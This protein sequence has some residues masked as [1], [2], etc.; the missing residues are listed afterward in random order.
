MDPTPTPVPPQP[1]PPMP[2][3]RSFIGPIILICIGVFFLV[4]NFVPSFDPWEIMARY[5]PVILIL[6]GLGRV[7]DYYAGKRSPG[8]TGA[9]GAT[10]LVVAVVLLMCLLGLGVWRS[11]SDS[12]N[13]PHTTTHDTQT[14]DGGG[15]TAVTANINFGVGELNIK[16]GAAHLLDGDFTHNEVT[17]A[18]QLDY[19]VD[20]GHGNLNLSEKRD[21]QHFGNGNDGDTQWNLA[22]SNS[23]PLDLTAHIGTGQTDMNL[24]GVNLTHLEVHMGVGEMKLD[25][26]GPRTK[27]LSVE[28][29]GG[30][31]EGR[32][33]LP[34][35][36]GI[37][38]HIEGGIGDISTDGFTKDG[39]EYVNAAYGKTPTS[40]DLDV[41]GGIGEIHLD[42]E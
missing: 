10:G 5:W 20:G 33:R 37:K 28:I 1:Q 27:N 19:S 9:S 17:G 14:V 24:A 34:K 32:I 15:A 3:S 42:Q 38:A 29:H 8:M 39:N 25:L 16:G 31:G 30:I 41:H 18:P 36:V 4:A 35:D 40:I 2:R 7:W 13:A 11:N 21:Q 22:L 6:V 23:V 26:T 12:R